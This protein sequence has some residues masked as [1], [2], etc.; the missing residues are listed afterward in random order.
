LNVSGKNKFIKE[1]MDSL[2][3][4]SA[5]V[6]HLNRGENGGAWNFA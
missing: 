4:L 6:D 5:N 2:K 3:L 1:V